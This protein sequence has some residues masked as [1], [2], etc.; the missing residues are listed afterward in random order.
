MAYHPTSNRDFTESFFGP[1]EPV[2]PPGDPLSTAMP[3]TDL[4]ELA[5]K[6][7]A[8]TGPGLAP[9]LAMDLALQM[10]LNEIAGQACVATAGTGAAIALYRDGEL[11]CRASHGST[12]PPL[13][14]RLAVGTGL[15]GE[16]MRTKQIQLCNDVQSDP[17]AH[18]EA[19][20]ILGVRSVA[21]L[22]LMHDT[23]IRGIFEVLS[24]QHSAF[25]E[26]DIAK[27]RVLADRILKNLNCAAEPGPTQVGKSP[28]S[29]PAVTE[30]PSSVKEEMGESRR[31]GTDAL[32]WALAIIVLACAGWLTLRIAQRLAGQK[33]VVH[34]GRSSEALVGSR[35]S[36]STVAATASP[37]ASPP[38]VETSSTHRAESRV[39]KGGLRVYENGREVFR[40]SPSSAESEHP[41]ETGVV[42]ASTIQTDQI[43]ELPSNAAESGL[44]HRVEPEYPEEARLQGIQGAVVLEVR[45]QPDGAVEHV[46]VLSGEPILAD[47]AV[48][49]VKQW[50]FKSR[51]IKGARAEMQTTITLN[52]RL[53]S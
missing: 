19:C 11:V 25:D 39:P 4:E 13:G 43:L 40:I 38:V 24:T 12:A 34:K 8:P 42:Q 15:S 32:T 52:F 29:V 3:E 22:P 35:T 46:R 48:K 23:G 26:Y 21:V 5:A 9:D 45:I 7:S 49:A 18:G 6:L 33:T 14:S 10:V 36:T 47:A 31:G 16:C 50:Q 2:A 44:A 30:E 41:E 27:L 51:L 1:Q 20:T 17:R 37:A 53:P 28:T